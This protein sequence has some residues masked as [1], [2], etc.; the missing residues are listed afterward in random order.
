[1]PITKVGGVVTYTAPK[2]FQRFLDT[3]VINGTQFA[4]S[5][6]ADKLKQMKFDPS[7]QATNTTT[8]LK[9]NS[10]ATSDVTIVLPQVSGTTFS[11][12][13]KDFGAN[14]PA[15]TDRDGLAQAQTLG[16]AGNLT[17]NGAGISGGLYTN[18]FYGGRLVTIYS[19]G[20]LSAITFTV[21]GT[22]HAGTAQ[23]ENI[24]GPNNGTA[25][26]TKYFNTVTSIAANA[27]VASNV[28][29]GFAASL[30]ALK[31]DKEKIYKV[32]PA[33]SETVLIAVYGEASG[34]GE[35]CS[36]WLSSPAT[37][38]LAWANGTAPSDRRIYFAGGTEPTPTASGIDWYEFV[39]VGE[40]A[41]GDV[42]FYGF[43]SGQD[44]KA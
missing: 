12:P 16:A 7:P 1:M 43:V 28:E 29:A 13:I 23:T 38:T 39:N 42:I 9:S 5:D 26:G 6:D 37:L 17:L 30:I 27:A 3:G 18:P 8:T 19:A 36:M 11:E 31:C 35:S 4:I 14:I 24:T 15:A 21:T 33:N 41:S 20:N 40:T 34:L 22:D 2:D 44:L 25:T 10:N 32:N